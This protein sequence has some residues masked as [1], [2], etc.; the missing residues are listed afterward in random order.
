MATSPSRASVRHCSELHNKNQ[1]AF[2][3][4]IKMGLLSLSFSPTGIMS[5][6]Q[7]R[8]EMLLNANSL[9]LLRS[10]AEYS[11]QE[12]E[13]SINYGLVLSN[14]CAAPPF[15]ISKA[16]YLV[17]ALAS[18]PLA[19]TAYQEVAAGED[20]DEQDEEGW[21]AEDVFQQY[22]HYKLHEKFAAGSFGE[23]WRA[24]PECSGDSCSLLNLFMLFIVSY[25]GLPLLSS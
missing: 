19:T 14:T 5:V 13:R 20:S 15:P 7:S 22:T 1:S 24:L 25:Y 21:T 10:E 4:F 23:V 2:K 6:D 16:K 18:L 17:E 11:L 9:A 12:D 3:K 8:D